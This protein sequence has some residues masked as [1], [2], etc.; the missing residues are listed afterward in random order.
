MQ[1][2]GTSCSGCVIP[3]E[4]DRQRAAHIQIWFLPVVAAGFIASQV[5][6][7]DT[8]D[9]RHLW[10]VSTALGL[11]YGSLF[12]VMPMLVLEWFGM[13]EWTLTPSAPMQT[14][15]DSQLQPGQSPRCLVQASLPARGAYLQNY[16][17]TCVAP[18]IGGNI[19]NLLF[20]RIYDSNTV[21]PRSQHRVRVLMPDWPGRRRTRNVRHRRYRRSLRSQHVRTRRRSLRRSQA[22]LPARPAVLL[23]RVQD[24]HVRLCTGLWTERHRRV[25]ARA[26]K[27]DAE[28]STGACVVC[29]GMWTGLTPAQIGRDCG[30]MRRA[31]ERGLHFN[32][33]LNILHDALDGR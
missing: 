5:A 29:I 22:R 12:N 28:V 25:Q 9:V 2:L 20:G 10:M 21:R 17:W 26:A 23:D 11:S 24:L 27:A 4:D 7:Q 33:E 31:H 32:E 15:D 18:V 6:A 16:G 19:F 30:V 13:G 1:R 8:L 14:A 3:R